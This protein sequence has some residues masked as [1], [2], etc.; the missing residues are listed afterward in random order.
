MAI[1]RD[2]MFNATAFTNKFRWIAFRDWWD[3]RWVVMLAF[4]VMFLGI[5]YLFLFWLLSQNI[6]GGGSGF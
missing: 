3:R 6:S 1:E 5:M 4:L 2:T